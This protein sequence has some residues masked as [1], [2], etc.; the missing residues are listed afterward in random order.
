MDEPLRLPSNL[1][2]LGAAYGLAWGLIGTRALDFNLFSGDHRGLALALTLSGIPVG[3]VVTRLLARFI[4]RRPK[5][6]L[7]AHAALSLLAGSLLFSLGLMFIF[8]VE[9]AC[10]PGGVDA[11]IF[12]FPLMIP[13][14]AFL[15]IWPL[16]LATLNC[17]D[18]RRRVLDAQAG[19]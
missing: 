11:D 14:F 19:A 5:L 4:A 12:K 6:L 10:G 17:W 3:I 8:I 18:L 2:R 9:S 16:L 15:S 7:V 13:F 1:N